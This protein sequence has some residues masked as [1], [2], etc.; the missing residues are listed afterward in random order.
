MLFL[1]SVTF[2]IIPSETFPWASI[3]STTCLNFYK[4]NKAA[5]FI[6]FY[7]I[8]FLIS[9]IYFF[10]TPLTSIA[11]NLFA[12]LNIILSFFLFVGINQAHLTKILGAIKTILILLVAFGILQTFKLTTFLGELYTFMIPRGNYEA[13]THINRGA[14]LLST[15]PSRAAME[16]VFLS[17]FSRKFLHNNKRLFDIT[18]L[19]FVNLVVQGGYALL[20][21]LIYLFFSLKTRHIKLVLPL[22]IILILLYIERLEGYRIYYIIENLIK[23][24]SFWTTLIGL[25]GFR[26]ISLFAAIYFSV[27][28]PVG[29][30]FGNW[31][32]SSI[33]ALKLTGLDPSTI[34]YFIF[35]SDGFWTPVRPSSIFASILMDFGLLGGALLVGC[36]I[37]LI[38]KKVKLYR[39]NR[40]IYI[41]FLI[42]FFA[43]GYLGHPIPIIVL[44]LSLNKRLNFGKSKNQ[45]LSPI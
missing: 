22:F 39:T 4:T 36:F 2:G 26:L 30:G 37:W 25:S 20:Y 41:A 43:F 9:S 15:E 21:S 23:S 14:S 1:P 11:T 33:L 45:P 32:E 28:N 7:F 34:P 24:E 3:Y 40:D 10:N 35:V 8:L 38:R 13:L 6:I 16:V 12:Y 5:L 31:E 18:I 17:M 44:A 29:G 42:Y 27:M 19:I